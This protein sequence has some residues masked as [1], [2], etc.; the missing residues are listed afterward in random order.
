MKIEETNN[1][2]GVVSIVIE[3][4]GNWGHLGFKVGNQF[5]YY[6]DYSSPVYKDTNVAKE[7][8]KDLDVQDKTVMDILRELADKVVTELSGEYKDTMSS[9]IK[10][11]FVNNATVQGHDRLFEYIVAD[12]NR[13]EEIVKELVDNFVLIV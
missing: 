1:G 5:W 2:Y 13:K 3:E 7:Y 8:V 11:S 9:D 4:F 12:D 10:E 6:E